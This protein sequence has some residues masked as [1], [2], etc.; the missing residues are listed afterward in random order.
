MDI[1]IVAFTRGMDTSSLMKRA[2]GGDAEACRILGTM[3]RA[4]DG[5]EKD[6]ARAVGLLRRAAELGDSPS[7]A[8]LGYMYLT[9]ECTDTDNDAAERYLTIA[10]D[11]GDTSAMC[12]LGY[13]MMNVRGHRDS[14]LAWFSRAADA[15]SLKGIKNLAAAHSSGTT[16]AERSEAAGLYRRA[17]DMGDIDSMCVLASILR[18]GTGV[19]VDK[20]GAAE[21]Y[22]RAADLGDM[23]AQY[24]LAFM[25]DSGEGIPMDRAEAERYFRM[26]ADQGDTD[27]CLCIGGILYERGDYGGAEGY[28]LSAAMKGDV[29]AQYNLGLMYMDGSLGEPD[30]AKATEWFESAASE[31]FAYAHTML[32]TM[33]LDDGRLPE[34]EK[35]FR[36][37]AEQGEPT[38][39]YNLGAL[40]LSGQ[41]RMG[42]EEAVDLLTRAASA[43]VDQAR[44]LLLKL[45]SL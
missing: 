6:C 43:G 10:A 32:G 17:A 25:L 21:L 41:I 28:F 13:L 7:A 38:A 16:D 40:A 29:K 23:G 8:S 19:P 39:Q 45:T 37:A 14:A 9:G 24:D 33:C 31:R 20:P 42:Y 30:R 44:E 36:A 11:A 18:N 12:N 15:G 2:E 3:Y 1:N 35:H 5:V 22:R 4:G 34:A 27:A 26:S